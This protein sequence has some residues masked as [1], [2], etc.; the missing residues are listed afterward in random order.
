MRLRRAVAA[1]PTVSSCSPSSLGD[2]D[3]HSVRLR[4]KADQLALVSA[5]VGMAR[6]AEVDRL[7][8]VGLAGAVGAVDDGQPRR[9]G[10]RRRV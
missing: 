9:R 5:C 10:E 4:P 3:H 2:A 6:A 1:K 7:E 8:Q